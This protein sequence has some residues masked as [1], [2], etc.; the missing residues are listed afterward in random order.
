MSETTFEQAKEC[1]K[2]GKP[3]EDVETKHRWSDTQ[4]ARVELHIIFCRNPLCI[5]LDTN[6][7]VQ[8]NPDGS[9]PQAYSQLGPKQ[10]PKLSQE[11]ET[12]IQDNIRKQLEAETQEGGSEVYN[13]HGG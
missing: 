2:C 5:W 12:R 7:I 4:G 10:F 8:V 9:I 11:T 13:P 1:P 3:G 6:W